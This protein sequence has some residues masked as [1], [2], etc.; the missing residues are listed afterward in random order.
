MVKLLDTLPSGFFTVTLADPGVV[1]T[2][3]GT[4]AVRCV[5]LSKVVGTAAPLSCTTEP[6]T[7]PVPGTLNEKAVPTVIRLGTGS[8]V[9][10]GPDWTML[11]LYDCTA[12]CG[13]GVSLSLTLTL[14]P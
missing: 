6:E 13:V 9:I 14:K 11:P 3:A 4:L 2:F 1:S 10:V 8:D 12:A 7:N 5:T